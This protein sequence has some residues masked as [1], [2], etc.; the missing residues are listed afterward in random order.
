[1]TTSI[2]LPMQMRPTSQKGKHTHREHGSAHLAK[3][4]RE[5]LRVEKKNN[6]QERERESNE[7]TA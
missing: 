7:Y 5:T 6:R 2:V 4:E 3:V 1:M